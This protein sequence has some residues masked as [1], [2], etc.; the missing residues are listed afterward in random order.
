[1]DKNKTRK[2]AVKKQ[3][4]TA[5]ESLRNILQRDSLFAAR[6]NETSDENPAVF[7]ICAENLTFSERQLLSKR[8]DAVVCM[9]DDL[10]SRISRLEQE[11]ERLSS[12]VLTDPLT[13]LYNFR[14]FSNQITIEIKRTRRTGSTFS[15]MML[16][17]DNFKLLND[18]LGHNEGNEFLKKIAE[19]F[20]QQLRPTDIACRFGGD[21]FAIILPATNHI[22]TNLA[23]H[24]IRESMETLTKGYNLP[25]TFSIGLTEYTTVTIKDSRELIDSADKALYKAKQ[26]GKNRVFFEERP[27]EA[28]HPAAVSREEKTALFKKLSVKKNES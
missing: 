17:V 13:G 6:I 8:A 4:S 1:M 18:T 5:S 19:M 9:Q 21:E 12:L 25:V 24:R 14:Y 11:N 27:V 20:I 16:D 3:S 15:L 22:D 2:H 23:A 28:P 10:L 7:L 26:S